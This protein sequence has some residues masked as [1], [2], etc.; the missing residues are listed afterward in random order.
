MQARKPFKLYYW[1][2][3]QGRGEFVRLALEDAGTA[4]LDVARLPASE[5]GGVPAL[6]TILEHGL[7]GI[8]PFAPPV[9]VD[10]ELLV[11]QVA[12]ILDYV[13][14]KL[15]LIAPDEASRV[16]ARQLQLT[17]ADFV[18]ETHDTHHPIAVSL[19]YEDQKREAKQKAQFFA[20]E[21]MPKFLGFFERVLA[22]NAHPEG[23]FAVG[24]SHSYVD[25]SLFQVLSGLAYAFPKALALLAPTTPRLIALR[26]RVVQRPGV[27]QYLAS[28][29]RLPFNQNGIFRHYPELDLGPDA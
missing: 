28:P 14:P 7:S 12:N 6:K 20:A 19:V 22:T 5:G 27:A 15:N 25:L 2:G 13:A 17:I 23:P 24:Q 3:I 8:R 26:D 4:Y 11:F 29:R 16:R 9:L 1:P 18:A 10:G 21:R